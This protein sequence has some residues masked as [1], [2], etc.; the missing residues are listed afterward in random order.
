[1]V[2]GDTLVVQLVP[3]Y[4]YHQCVISIKSEAK[5]TRLDWFTY[6]WV[7]HSLKY[8]YP[9]LGEKFNINKFELMAVRQLMSQ[10]LEVFFK[11]F[12]HIIS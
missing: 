10:P 12:P 1:M 8:G 2:Q 5:S 7:L 9:Y 3:W 11:V 4:E 6:L